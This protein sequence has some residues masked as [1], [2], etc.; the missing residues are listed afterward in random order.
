MFFKKRTIYIALLVCFTRKYVPSSMKEIRSICDPAILRSSELVIFLVFN[1][2]YFL[3]N[4]YVS[5]KVVLYFRQ[6]YQ[7]SSPQKKYNKVSTCL[8]WRCFSC[9]DSNIFKIN[10]IYF[11]TF[12]HN[13][14]AV[15][16]VMLYD[17]V[18]NA[19]RNFKSEAVYLFHNFIIK[20]THF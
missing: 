7:D 13:L 4:Y 3:W 19:S 10:I 11:V 2:I 6:F 14:N 20:P 12:L 15:F 9:K 8:L 18:A 16:M 17:K 1:L 5:R